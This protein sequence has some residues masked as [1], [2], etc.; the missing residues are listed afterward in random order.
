[1]ELG[2]GRGKQRV[3]R[4]SIAALHLPEEIGELAHRVPWKS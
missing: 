1:V 3:T 2:V 4:R